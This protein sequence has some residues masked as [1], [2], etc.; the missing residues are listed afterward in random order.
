MSSTLRKQIGTSINNDFWCEEGLEISTMTHL[1]GQLA[2]L[3]W[4]DEGGQY[5]CALQVLSVVGSQMRAK[6]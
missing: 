3:Q 1:K 6:I 5:A 4:T 2:N